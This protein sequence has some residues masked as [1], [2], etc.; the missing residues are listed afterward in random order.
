MEALLPYIFAIIIVSILVY[1]FK[2]NKGIS[3]TGTWN[4]VAITNEAADIERQKREDE[5]CLH[6]IKRNA[7]IQFLNWKICHLTNTPFVQFPMPFVYTIY[8][9]PTAKYD[10]PKEKEAYAAF[11]NKPKEIYDQ[12]F[13]KLKQDFLDK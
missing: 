13:N 6:S 10:E 9:K 1:L 2:E 7:E 5:I 3:Y 8:H 4:P 12:H 11:P